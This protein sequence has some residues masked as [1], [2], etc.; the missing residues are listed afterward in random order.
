VQRPRIPKW[1]NHESF[2]HHGEQRWPR[3]RDAL[4]NSKTR[5]DY[6]VVS[7]AKTRVPRLEA[8]KARIAQ[9]VGAARSLVRPRQVQA[10]GPGEGL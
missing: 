2:E 7:P 6:H 4:P 8:L 3:A 9:F 1:R 10:P 5:V